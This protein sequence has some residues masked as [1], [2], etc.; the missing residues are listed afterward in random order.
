MIVMDI[1]AVASLHAHITFHTVVLAEGNTDHRHCYAKVTQHHAPVT[2]G[3]MA[4]TTPET[5]TVG[6]TLVQLHQRQDNHPDRHDQPH[7]R[8][9]GDAVLQQPRQQDRQHQRNH[10]RHAQAAPQLGR[11]ITTPAH[12][13]PNPHQQRHRRHQPGKH[14][15]EE[16][17]AD[18]NTAQA[19]LFM[20]Q[21]QQR[22]QQHHQHRGNQQYVV[23]QQEGFTR[24][25]LMLHP[26][27][28]LPTLDGV[29]QQRTA[30]HNHQI[31]EDK[32]TARRIGGKG[33]H[34]HQHAGAH[35]EGPQQ[36]QREG[37]NRQQ[38]RPGLESPAL[39][40]H[41]QRVHQRRTG[42]PRHK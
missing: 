25:S 40:G 15:I 2:A 42:Q 11:F 12:Q 6:G 16:G 24:E 3:E 21:R 1:H 26:A 28:H 7:H 29:Q 13:R 41:C 23:T 5:V 39:F 33:V 37:G 20:H 14:G 36:T 32:H 31:G 9:A 17:F 38:H 27:A 8:H 22:A 18:R 34:R 30:D 4:Q 10:Q 35:Q 19:E